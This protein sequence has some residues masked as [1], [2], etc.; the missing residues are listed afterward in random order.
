MNCR[1]S[2]LCALLITSSAF[3]QGADMPGSSDHSSFPRV[4]GAE[5]LG[6]AFSDY[7]AGTF[8]M[9]DPDDKIIVE[10][11][12]GQRTRILYLN[13]T[14]DSPLMVQKNYESAFA[15]VGGVEEIYSCSAK[16]CS[17]HLLATNLWTRDTMVPTH[18]LKH[19]FYLLGFAHNFTNPTYRYAKVV[20][21]QS[22][23]HLGVFAATVADNNPNE[24]VRER[25]VTL[26]EILEIAD[27]E[28]TLEFVDATQMRTEIADSASSTVPILGAHW[29]PVLVAA[30]A[31]HSVERGHVAARQTVG[32]APTFDDRHGPL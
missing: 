7:D 31:P 22:L 27:F 8:L 11:P 6:F 4:A 25:T 12:E 29:Y 26:V 1:I 32:C 23:F 5:I 14:G 24:A 17:G 21:D 30:D 19:P 15:D 16:A 2:L 18:E 20:S 28:P 10:R 3:A 13:K 9:A